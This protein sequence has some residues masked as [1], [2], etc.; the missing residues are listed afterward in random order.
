MRVPQTTPTL[1]ERRLL[2]LLA[3]G[4]TSA[5]A[6]LALHLSPAEAEALLAD[7]LRRHDLSSKHQLFVRALVHRWI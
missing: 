2:A 1:P 4:R 5:E 3:L 6:A 7:L